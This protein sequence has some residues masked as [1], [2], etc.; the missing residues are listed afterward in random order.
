MLKKIGIPIF[1]FS[2]LINFE[3]L[4][5]DSKD[6]ISVTELVQRSIYTFQNLKVNKDIKNFEAYFKNSKAILIFPELY[7]GSLIFGAK[8]GNGILMIRNESSWSG[9]FFYSLGGVSV[10]LQFGVKV[11][12]VV[13]TIMTDRGLKSLLKEKIKIGV[14]LNAAIAHKGIG[15][16]AESTLRLADIYSFS[17]NKGLFL[18]GSF[19]G[20]FIQQRNDFNSVYHGKKFTIDEILSDKEINL[21]QNKLIEILNR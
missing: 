16:S 6:N 10:G 8:A 1:L 19:D 7:E 21:K 5:A 14:D 12:K 3:I 9:P 11:G 4:K 18:G 13:F 2:T 17:E 20:S 15:Y